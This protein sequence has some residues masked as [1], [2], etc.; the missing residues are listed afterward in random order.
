VL[1]HIDPVT[2]RFKTPFE[3]MLDHERAENERLE[4]ASKVPAFKVP[5]SAI[6]DWT[7]Q[8]YVDKIVGDGHHFGKQSLVQ[9]TNHRKQ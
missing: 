2:G 4:A 9:S 1:R 5:K 8:E 7:G 6:D 3:V